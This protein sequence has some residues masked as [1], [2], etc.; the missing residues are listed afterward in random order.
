MKGLREEDGR[1]WKTKKKTIYYRTVENSQVY[2]LKVYYEKHCSHRNPSLLDSALR[3]VVKLVHV[4]GTLYPFS[5]LIISI[6][7]D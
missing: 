1:K 4:T 7:C 2:F 3:H 6:L 5:P